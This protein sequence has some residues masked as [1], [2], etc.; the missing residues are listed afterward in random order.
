MNHSSSPL[1]TIAKAGQD[2]QV[3]QLGAGLFSIEGWVL[4]WLACQCSWLTPVFFFQAQTL[5]FLWFVPK[6]PSTHWFLVTMNLEIKVVGDS[7][8]S[9]AQ[10]KAVNTIFRRSTWMQIILEMMAFL[11]YQNTWKATNTFESYFFSMWDYGSNFF[12]VS[13]WQFCA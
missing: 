1:R 4:Y 5:L 9:C 13:H 10:K 11:S 7:S 6:S 12:S 3:N 2:Q 8:I